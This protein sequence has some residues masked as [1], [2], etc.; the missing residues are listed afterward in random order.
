MYAKV[1]IIGN[2]G[3]DPETRYTKSGTMNVSFTIASNRRFTDQSGT[4]QER[5]T[6]FRVTAWGKLAETLDRL[7]ADGHL[8]K[9]RQVFVS[10]R[11]ES[12]EYTNQQ[13]E[14]KT[15]LEVNADDVFLLGSRGEAGDQG[16][17]GGGRSSQQPAAVAEDVD[18]LPF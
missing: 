2:V 3:R 15:S 13:G 17:M 14:Q 5:T 16:S 4:P 7:T 6:W 12:N 18:D 10:G 8:A 9:G 1:Q 11:L